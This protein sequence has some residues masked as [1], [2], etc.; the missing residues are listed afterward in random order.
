MQN[1]Y[2]V[3]ETEWKNGLIYLSSHIGTFLAFLGQFW[4]NLTLYEA[5]LDPKD[6]NLEFLWKIDNQWLKLS[7]KVA[8]FVSLGL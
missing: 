1:S 3:H 6:Q 2:S 4:P 5:K 8:L 7:G